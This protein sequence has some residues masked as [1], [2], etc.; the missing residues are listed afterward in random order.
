M[1]FLVACIIDMYVGLCSSAVYRDAHIMQVGDDYHQML[2]VV[3]L[4]CA[5]RVI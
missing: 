2:S 4:L 3:I 5:I 1:Y